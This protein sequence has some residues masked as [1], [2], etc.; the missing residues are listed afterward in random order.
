MRYSARAEC[1]G[2][3][4]LGQTRVRP[5]GTLL[6]QSVQARLCSGRIVFGRLAL[7]LGR[8]F[9]YDST[10]AESCL[11]GWH[12][13]Q[14]ECS[15]T[16]LLGQNRVLSVG[17]LL[18]VFGHDSARIESSSAA[19]HSARAECSG[20]TLLG[21]SSRS[22]RVLTS[23]SEVGT[24]NPQLPRPSSS[25]PLPPS[26]SQPPQPSTSQPSSSLP[27]KNALRDE[28]DQAKDEA[29][30]K[31]WYTV[32]E[33]SSKMSTEDLLELLR[34][35]PLPEGVTNCSGWY[36]IHSRQRLLKGGPK[37][38]KGW[39]S[40]YFFIG[41]SDKG[42]LPF[43]REW[44]PYCKDF[45]NLGKP[46][47]N[48]LTK[49]ILSHIKL[50]GGL[51]IDEPLSEQQLEWARI[52]PPKPVQAGV[53]TPPS[54]PTI[55]S[56]FPA[57]SAPLD[58]QISEQHL[59]YGVLPRDK[60]VFQNQTHDTFSCFAQAVY[61]ECWDEWLKKR[62]DDGL[63]IYELGFVKAKEMFTERFPDIPLDDFV[64]PAVIS[65][66]GETV[67]PSEA[68]DVAASHPPGEGPSGDA[69]EP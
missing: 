13:A 36:Y 49:H 52:I 22:D 42:K 46:A 60:E 14:A 28:K 68:G 57:E 6:G 65:P 21:L 24:S 11:A 54:A 48:N 37:S 34:E 69:P 44:N 12:S 1:S 3:T 62:A 7:C 5:L 58:S 9:G 38:N 15:G 39:H 43:D 67:L 47:P 41:H 64:L 16:T 29:N 40:K 59:V 26:S 18:G 33:K 25:E 50:R 55:S 19:W 63:E 35:Y 45:E 51:F 17:T 2:T 32:D 23:R 30:P 66:Y 27:V 53:V 56:T 10:R 61:M 31:P 20:T 4:L 8:V